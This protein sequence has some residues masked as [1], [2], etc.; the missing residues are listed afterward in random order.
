MVA[1]GLPVLREVGG[2]AV[3]YAPVGDIQAWVE[4]TLQV[5]HSPE[6]AESRSRRIVRG[7]S[8]SWEAHARIILGAY[9]RLLA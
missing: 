7:R 1:S 6:T 5:L 4:H 9:E 3:A 8:Y 2:D